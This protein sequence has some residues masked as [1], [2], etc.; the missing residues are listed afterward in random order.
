MF[1]LYQLLPAIVRWKDMASRGADVQGVLERVVDAFEEVVVD[2]ESDIERLGNE[3]DVDSIQL[4]LF[5]FLVHLVGGQI[6]A[7]WSATKRRVV[8]KT[9]VS[10]WRNKATHPSWR[11]W[12]QANEAVAHDG[13]ELW[14]SEIYEAECDYAPYQD[15]WHP[16]KAARWDFVDSDDWTRVSFA[17]SLIGEQLIEVFRP[18]HVLP[19]RGIRIQHP[20]DPLSLASGAFEG[21]VLGLFPDTAPVLTDPGTYVSPPD[22][23]GTSG[24]ELTI[25]CTAFC[26]TACQTACTNR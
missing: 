1:R 5:P 3:A 6:D 22:V 23:C 13:W 8:A 15:Y 25:N 9:L 12:L 16:Y 14:K 4:R 20:S 21:T 7:E 18:I 26:E 24:L 19:R 2:V 10:L 11:A 17:D